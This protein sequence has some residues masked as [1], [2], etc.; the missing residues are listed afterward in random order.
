MELSVLAKSTKNN[1]DV[2]A[3]YIINQENTNL[4]NKFRFVLHL[5]YIYKL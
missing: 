2:C 1:Y 5:E 3:Q 4:N